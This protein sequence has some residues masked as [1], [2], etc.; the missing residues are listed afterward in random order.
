VTVPLPPAAAAVAA[1]AAPRPT[2]GGKNLDHDMYVTYLL[3]HTDV[4]A[5]ESNT[6]TDSRASSPLVPEDCVRWI[7][8]MK[9]RDIPADDLDSDSED[10]DGDTDDAGHPWRKYDAEHPWREYD[11]SFEHVRHA[12]AKLTNFIF[13]TPEGAPPIFR[14]GEKYELTYVPL[15]NG[16]GSYSLKTERGVVQARVDRKFADFQ[17]YLMPETKEGWLSKT[18]WTVIVKTTQRKKIVV[19][20]TRKK[21]KKVAEADEDDLF[22]EGGEEEAEWEEYEEEQEQEPCVEVKFSDDVYGSLGH[23][24]HE[25]IREW[26]DL[27]TKPSSANLDEFKCKCAE[28]RQEL[29]H[30]LEEAGEATIFRRVAEDGERTVE[31]FAKVLNLKGARN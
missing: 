29:Q 15:E 19:K 16:M 11:A 8:F 18:L 13:T 14:P 30:R 4:N 23:A 10:E 27:T 22:G 3:N 31:V 9:R 7:Y 26:V 21:E 17:Q 28:A 20:K 1:V 12:N 6:D 24:N 2:Q 25:A 5:T